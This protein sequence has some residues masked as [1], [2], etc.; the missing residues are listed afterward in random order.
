MTLNDLTIKLTQYERK[1][2]ATML[3]CSSSNE[4]YYKCTDLMAK[5]KV[6]IDYKGDL[7][8]FEELFDNED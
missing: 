2:I 6:L 3:V 1:R 8:C 4:P 7:I 5:L